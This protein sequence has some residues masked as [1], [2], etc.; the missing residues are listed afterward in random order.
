MSF[1]S[2]H[3]NCVLFFAPAVFGKAIFRPSS[4][5]GIVGCKLTEPV[6]RTDGHLLWAC[7][8]VICLQGF[9]AQE[10]TL[11]LDTDPLYFITL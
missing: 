5:F 7:R 2:E 3:A 6:R 4:D 10:I 11:D 1:N 8:S 9:L